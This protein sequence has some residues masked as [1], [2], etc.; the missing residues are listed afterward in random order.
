MAD[1]LRTCTFIE[2]VNYRNFYLEKHNNSDMHLVTGSY[3]EAIK[4]CATN[5]AFSSLWTVH[6]LASV[7]KQ[8]ILSVYPPVNGLNDKCIGILT[9]L[10]TR[11]KSTAPK[12]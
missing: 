4:D 2:L 12:I 8:P 3:E 6:A 10:G 7:V 5:H 9:V 1:E 11:Y